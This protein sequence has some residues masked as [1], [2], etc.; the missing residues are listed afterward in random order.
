MGATPNTNTTEKKQYF[1]IH[2][3]SFTKKAQPNEEGAVM[4]TY[5]N[6]DKIEVNVWEYK[7]KDLSGV[8]TK[9]ETK[10]L[11]FGDQ[12]QITLHDM[13]E[14]FVAQIQ[15]DSNFA[16][17][18]IKRFPNID[19]KEPVK[20]VPYSFIPKEETR[21]K[22][23]INVFQS[24][25]KLASAYTKDNPNG[26]PTVESLAKLGVIDAIPDKGDWKIFFAQVSRFLAKEAMRYAEMLNASNPI[27]NQSAKGNIS[28][29][30]TQEQ[31]DYS[32]DLPF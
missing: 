15:A 28:Q 21:K 24:G 30:L 2:G 19:F 27:P 6:D 16:E 4:R 8:I 23:G 11:P 14:D 26:M 10:T 20:L 22:E 3:D 1:S 12:Y 5:L 7:F 9:I 32:E 13:G 18:L 17:T 29:E 31:I 25:E